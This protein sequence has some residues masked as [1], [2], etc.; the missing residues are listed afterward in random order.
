VSWST[1]ARHAAPLVVLVGFTL[2]D[3]TAGRGQVVYGLLVIVPL[4]A[5]FVLDRRATAGY[6]VTAFAAAAL[7]GVYNDQY[8]AQA[9]DTHLIRML[10]IALGGGDRSRRL[11]GAAAHRGRVGDRQ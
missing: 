7:L 6:A 9:I 1:R 8:T 5:G 3:F 2:L 4:V 10:G 11:H